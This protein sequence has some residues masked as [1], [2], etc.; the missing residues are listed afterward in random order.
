MPDLI[1]YVVTKSKLSMKYT[2]EIFNAAD[3]LICSNEH[4]SRCSQNV[5]EKHKRY[6][7]LLNDNTTRPSDLD[8]AFA[9][10]EWAQIYHQVSKE[11]YCLAYR[12]LINKLNLDQPLTPN[13][14]LELAGD[15]ITSK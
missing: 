10:Y 14:L 1:S 12:D 15:I 4:E 7:N 2:N 6:F 13:N 9:N 11:R 3:E 8:T 5:T